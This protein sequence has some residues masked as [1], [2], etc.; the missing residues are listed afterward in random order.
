[1]VDLYLITETGCEYC[2]AAKKAARKLDQKYPVAVHVRIHD[3]VQSPW[4]PNNRAFAKIDEPELVPSYAV[5]KQGQLLKVLEGKVLDVAA[6]ESW[7]G[8]A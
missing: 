4:P 7:L 6:L 5:V 1:M 8:L 3:I 2:E